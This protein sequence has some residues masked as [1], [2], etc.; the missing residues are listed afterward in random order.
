MPK[1]H[2]NFKS[3]DPNVKNSYTIS[4]YMGIALFFQHLFEKRTTP[5]ETQHWDDNDK[6]L[7]NF[8]INLK[9]IDRLYYIYHNNN[10][11][12]EK[13]IKFRLIARME[14]EEKKHIYV[15]LAAERCPHRGFPCKTSGGFIFVSRDVDFFMKL[16]LTRAEEKEDLN[17]EL[18]YKSLQNDSIYVDEI[19]SLTTTTSVPSLNYLCYEA[20]C[21]EGVT[22]KYY[23]LPKMLERSIDDFIKMKKARFDYNKLWGC[24][25]RYWHMFDNGCLL[26]IY[27]FLQ[28]FLTSSTFSPPF[29]S[30]L[31]AASKPASQPTSQPVDR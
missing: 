23:L 29:F 4:N 13:Q 25:C 30:N 3:V 10:N 31:L 5:W 14:E 24:H 20:I 21:Q 2:P 9:K 26:C 15:E 16:V 18:I 12:F 17:K 19:T 28:S 27:C 22:Y 7:Q 1:T 6:A 11:N 8:E